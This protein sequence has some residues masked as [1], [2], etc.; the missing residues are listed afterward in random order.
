MSL[1]ALPWLLFCISVLTVH[2]GFALAVR[3]GHIDACWPYW[4]GCASISKVGRQ[5]DAAHLY[6]FGL[7]PYAA[8]L[9]VYWLLNQ[10]WMRQLGLRRGADAMAVCGIASALALAVYLSVLGSHGE[11]YQFMR[12]VGV[13]FHFIG[14]VAA[15][16]MLVHMLAPS[17]RNAG[18]LRG[19]WRALRVLLFALLVMGAL[20]VAG[21][22]GHGRGRRPGERAGVDRHGLNPAAIA[23]RRR[24]VATQRTA[25]ALARRRAR[26]AARRGLTGPIIMRA[27]RLRSRSRR[28]T[29]PMP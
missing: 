22:L 3:E 19:P 23:L 11:L 28:H 2:V 4:D 16:A 6:R 1:A 5:G 13:M 29:E 21:V 17:C 9:G 20:S 18:P 7:L 25:P 8:L 26:A 15:H 14:A 24:A 10:G 12:R 27:R